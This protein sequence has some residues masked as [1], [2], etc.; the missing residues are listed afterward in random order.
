MNDLSFIDVEMRLDTGVGA[1]RALAAIMHSGPVSAD[2]RNDLDGVGKDDAAS[3]LHLIVRELESGQ[4]ALAYIQSA[5]A[6][7]LRG[8]PLRPRA[9]AMEAFFATFGETV[10][11]EPRKPSK[12]NA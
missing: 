5:Y 4:D 6:E 8:K 9:E 1:L 10:A 7:F 3:L 11:P 12:T 2:H